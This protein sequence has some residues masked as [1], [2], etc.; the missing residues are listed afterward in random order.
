[1]LDDSPFDQPGDHLVR[2]F[3][4]GFAAARKHDFRR[5]GAL[6]GAGDAGEVGLSSPRIALA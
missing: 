5:L 1:V 4:S 2:R 3:F 6:V